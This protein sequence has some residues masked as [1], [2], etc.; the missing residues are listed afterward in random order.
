MN[1]YQLCAGVVA[2][3][4]IYLVVKSTQDKFASVIL[5]AGGL[6]ILLFIVEKI[7]P[8]I[9]FAYQLATYAEVNEIYFRT[10]LK[11]IAICYLSEITS[12]ICKDFGAV[13]W[14]DKIVLAC[15]CSM[16]IVA[17]PLFEEFLALVTRF[18]K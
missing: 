12:G 1:I 11:A 18:L 13:T 6:L 9:K 10:V 14:A 8:L 2:S 17:L 4:L 16:L 5:I 3:L 7:P 15:R